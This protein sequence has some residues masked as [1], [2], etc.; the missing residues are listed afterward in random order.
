MYLCEFRE[1]FL[2]IVCFKYLHMYWCMFYVYFL[3]ELFLFICE[4]IW[5]YVG[6]SMYGRGLQDERGV[7][8]CSGSDQY[9][10]SA[11]E[12]SV[13]LPLGKEVDRSVPSPCSPADS[14]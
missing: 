8:R 13:L 9:S 14:P 1:L 6:R 5:V 4:H 10:A 12:D 7:C 3:Q 2:C 11:N